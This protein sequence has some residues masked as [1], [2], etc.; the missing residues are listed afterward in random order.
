MLLLIKPTILVD[1]IR[2]W[3][4]LG[5]KHRNMLYNSQVLIFKQRP[6]QYVWAEMHV[7]EINDHSPESHKGF[8]V[9]HFLPV[10]FMKTIQYQQV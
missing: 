8:D 9:V 2:A 7:I 1:E 5:Y 3:L 6:I 10:L 4:V